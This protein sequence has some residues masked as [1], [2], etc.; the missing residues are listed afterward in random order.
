[1]QSKTGQQHPPTQFIHTSQDTV[2]LYQS[3][4]KQLCPGFYLLLQSNL[5]LRCVTVAEHI[6]VVHVLKVGFSTVCIQT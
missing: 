5:L 6:A 3:L 4:E 1:M 2:Q